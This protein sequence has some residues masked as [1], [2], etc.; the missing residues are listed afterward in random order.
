MT[1]RDDD[2]LECSSIRINKGKRMD[3]EHIRQESTGLANVECDRKRNIRQIL[4]LG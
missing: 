4:A 3:Q 1:P 2:G